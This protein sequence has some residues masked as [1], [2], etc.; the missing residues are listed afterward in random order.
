MYMDLANGAAAARHFM[1]VATNAPT[2]QRLS[3]NKLQI[4]PP[5]VYLKI[6]IKKSD[7]NSFCLRRKQILT[8]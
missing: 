2:T 7:W 8:S 6:W 3:K 4:Y 1:H 5:E